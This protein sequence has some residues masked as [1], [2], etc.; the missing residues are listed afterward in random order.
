MLT[1]SLLLPNKNSNC[2]FKNAGGEPIYYDGYS[3]PRYKA[4]APP[5]PPPPPM[6]TVASPA[7]AASPAAPAQQQPPAATAPGNTT[8]QAP[9]APPCSANVTAEE[10]ARAIADRLWEKMAAATK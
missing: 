3:G 7:P 5:L 10:L 2:P 9:D 1:T 6:T 8:A 4:P